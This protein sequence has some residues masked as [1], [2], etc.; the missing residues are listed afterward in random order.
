LKRR[1]GSRED[2]FQEISLLNS[3]VKK[4]FQGYSSNKKDILENVLEDGECSASSDKNISET[5]ECI[6]QTEEGFS[7]L[8]ENISNGEYS[9]SFSENIL[10]AKKMSSDMKNSDILSVL[11]NSPQEIHDCL[12]NQE[13]RLIVQELPNQAEAR[14][15][16]SDK[17]QR[18]LQNIAN[19]IY[20]PKVTQIMKYEKIGYKQ[21]KQVLSTLSI[22]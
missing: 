3:E 2:S 4:S 11:E 21:A 13:R 10:E 6:L 20:E 1:E 7:G 5:Q 22:Y 18:I 12:L 8:L 9:S 14:I 16:L 15:S 19:K 17:Y